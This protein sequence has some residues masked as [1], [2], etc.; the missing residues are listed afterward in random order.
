MEKGARQLGRAAAIAAAALLGAAAVGVG[1]SGLEEEIYRRLA[2]HDDVAAAELIEKYL[3]RRPNDPVMLYN[4]ACVRTRLNEPER[5]ATFLINAVKAGFN[6]FSHMRRDPDLRPLHDHGI[7]NAILRARDAADP[8]LAKRQ[9]D[10]W[11]ER[12]KTSDYRIEGD[13]ELHVNFV[14]TLDDAA[15]ASISQLLQA[16]D[17]LL[18][19]ELFGSPPR[20]YVLIA[21]LD[22]HDAANRLRDSH[23]PGIYRHRRRELITIDTGRSLRHEFVHVVHHSHMDELGQEHPLWIQEGL[24]AL[25]EVYELSADGAAAFGPNDRQNVAKRMARTG[26]LMRWSELMAISKQTLPSEA[27]RFYSQLRSFFRFMAERELLKPWYVDYTEHFDNDNSGLL[28]LE[29]VFGLSMG[30]IDRNWRAWL[31]E[32][33]T[34]VNQAM[35]KKSGAALEATLPAVDTAR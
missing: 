25:F 14:T 16:Q 17:D 2:D 1:G 29:R 24:A 6:D 26:E 8:L 30:E 35:I 18:K 4:G 3:Q 11:R 5:A 28:S 31:D 15:L 22:A 13:D 32:Q 27:G 12:Y 23:T 19:Q 20:H 10:M 9:V 33:P 7:Y 21:L 34:I